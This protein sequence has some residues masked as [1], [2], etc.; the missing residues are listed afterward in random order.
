MTKL[1]S[2]AL[3]VTGPNSALRTIKDL[4]DH[5]K[6]RPAQLTYGHSGV[7]SGTHFAS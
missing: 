4:I 1:A 7:G 2:T 5:A 6:K 3:F